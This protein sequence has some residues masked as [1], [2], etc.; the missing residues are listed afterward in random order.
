MEEW[1]EHPAII[2]E[3]CTDDGW[4]VVW[5]EDKLADCSISIDSGLSADCP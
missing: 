1:H 4:M 5:E 3:T 2:S